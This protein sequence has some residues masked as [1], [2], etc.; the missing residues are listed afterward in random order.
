MSSL[1][2]KIIANIKQSTINSGNFINSEN[3][4]CIDSSNNRIGINTKD[5]QYA[6]DVSGTD[7]QS[8][9]NSKNLLITNL[10]KIEEISNNTLNAKDISVNNFID[11]SLGY[12]ITLSGDLIDASFI[13]TNDL[14]IN[15]IYIPTISCDF[16]EVTNELDA[17]FIS[18]IEINV[19]KITAID[20]DF[21]ELDID[22]MTVNISGNIELLINNELSSNSITVDEISANTL[23]VNKNA[24]FLQDTSFNNINIDGDASF[25]NGMN[26]TGDADFGNI[27]A[28]DITSDGTITASILDA[29]TIKS[30]GNTIIDN[31]ALG[32]TD[33]DA[34]FNE[35]NTK[36]INITEQAIIQG[37]LEF[38]NFG[39]FVL[40][41]YNSNNYP[42]NDLND[43]F[44]AYDYVNNVLKI[45][46]DNWNDILFT[47]NYANYNL[48][49]NFSGNEIKYDIVQE[50]FYIENS[51]N[52]IVKPNCKYIPLNVNTFDGIK[53]GNNLN[54][55]YYPKSIVID[56][57]SA[58]DVFEIHANVSL[59]YLNK[60]PGD[61]EPNNYTFGIYPDISFTTTHS[62]DISQASIDNS[63]VTIKNTI[64]VLD[65][66]YNYANS[67]LSYIGKLD[68][69]DSGVIS[70]RGFSF[71]ISSNKDINY[72]AIDSFNCTIKQV[73]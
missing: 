5:P 13:V 66:S 3:V 70:N 32:G 45:Y 10:A 16:I 17:S 11:I 20:F 4:I 31:G 35:I 7:T 67:S 19:N 64:L 37:E 27:N 21:P 12:F 24:Y 47:T 60:I 62:G 14:S 36:T 72:I 49:P 1:T 18:A 53:F 55:T 51:N 63:Y 46:N 43:G 25:N 73:Q 44:M 69:N 61:V 22:Y 33:A 29:I 26:V 50:N 54:G 8:M 34:T 59:R 52:L 9:I 41:V 68:H 38:S 71:Y 30:G 40:P 65:N 2:N 6:I 39:R 28:H 57:S 58:N 15:H 42:G 23:Y 56:N 48:K